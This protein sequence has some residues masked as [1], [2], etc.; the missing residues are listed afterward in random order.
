MKLLVKHNLLGTALSKAWNPSEM[1]ETMELEEREL[2]V[3]GLEEVKSKI[4]RNKNLSVKNCESI[5]FDQQHQNYA[6][7]Q[8]ISTKA[9]REFLRYLARKRGK[10]YNKNWPETNNNR[11]AS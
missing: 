1:S 9:T 6:E 11:K 3:K 8:T 5:F 7:L 10:N 4:I 2:I